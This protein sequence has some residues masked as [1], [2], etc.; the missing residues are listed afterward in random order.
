MIWL[1]STI[2][3]IFF[4]VWCVLIAVLGLPSL[5]T[6]RS[7]LAA[8]RFWSRGVLVMARLICGIRFEVRGREHLPDGPC[9]VA[10]QHQAAFETF[11][12]FLLFQYPVFVMKESL[13]W[14]PL[15]GWYIK[16]GGLVGINR[17]AGAGAIRRMLRAAE[18]A[19]GRNETLLIFP[20]GTRTAPGENTSYKPGVVALYTHT[21]APVIP[22]ALNTGYFWG[23]TRLLKVPGKI[24]FEFLPALPQGLNKA[25]FLNTLRERI[26]TASAALPRP[27]GQ[28][29]DHAPDQTVEKSVG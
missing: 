22:M 21:E 2:Y 19:L 14:I 28:S 6:R 27:G 25:D 16:R 26:E 15:I 10:A 17:S 12:L 29:S 9:I 4:L 5:V 11:A 1:R 23:K 20:E 7:A 8:I 18:R 3:L 13:Q 24:V